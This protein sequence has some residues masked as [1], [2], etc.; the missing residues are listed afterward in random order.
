MRLVVMYLLLLATHALGS[1]PAIEAAGGAPAAG[2]I[3]ALRNITVPHLSGIFL[4]IS[5]ATAQ[6]TK[7]HS[8]GS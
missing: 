4:S 7:A 8:H 2:G 6:W 1:S 3:P 5:P